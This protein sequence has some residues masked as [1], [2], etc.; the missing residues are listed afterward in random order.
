MTKNMGTIDRIVRVAL[1]VIIAMLYFAGVVGGTFGVI[2]LVL[3][4]VF[5]LTSLVGFCPLYLPFKI[6]TFKA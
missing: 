2:L 5:L 3:G 6:K 1:A 4:G